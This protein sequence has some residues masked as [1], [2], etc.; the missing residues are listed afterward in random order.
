MY[1]LV[2]GRATSMIQYR[3]SIDLPESSM[4][5]SMPHKPTS[6]VIC[7]SSLTVVSPIVAEALS[8]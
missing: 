6:S 1:G 3:S 2:D 7:P 4:R 8:G 5:V